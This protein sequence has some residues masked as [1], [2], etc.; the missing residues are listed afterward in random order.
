MVNKLTNE[1]YELILKLKKEAEFTFEKYTDYRRKKHDVEKL[2]KAFMTYVDMIGVRKYRPKN[3]AVKDQH[4]NSKTKIFTAGELGKIT[5]Y[6]KEQGLIEVDAWGMYVVKWRKPTIDNN[7]KT[8]MN[9]CQQCGRP[10]YGKVCRECFESEK[11]G[12]LSSMYGARNRHNN[13]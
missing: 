2:S 8:K 13:K 5:K 3:M 9:K 11:G 1:Q 4:T 7:E 6:L 12:R 10:C